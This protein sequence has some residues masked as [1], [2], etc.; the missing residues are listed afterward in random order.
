MGDTNDGSSRAAPSAQASVTSDTAV[1]HGGFFS[2]IIDVLSPSDTG[3]D[4][5][6]AVDTSSTST[7]GGLGNLRAMRLED[8]AIPKV[9][10]I[11]VPADI[12][13]D[14][15]VQL[16]RQSGLTRIPVYEGTLDTPIGLIHLKDFALKHGFEGNGTSFDVTEVM[17]PLLFAPPSMPIGVLLQKMQTAR[18]H[19]AL[20]IDE[21]GG[22]DGL[23][24]LED[25]VEQV[26]G[27]IE[28][29]HDL[30][31]DQFWTLEKPGCYLAVA[32]TPLDEFEAEIDASLTGHDEIDEEDIET[33]GGLVFML[34]GRVPERGEVVAH[35]AGFEFEV[36]DAD[37]RRIKRLR[38]R[39]PDGPHGAD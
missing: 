26:I 17:R 30:D 23:V 37:P 36:V 29:E 18:I 4:I 32:R 8:V 27:E 13:K 12:S 2:R 1:A 11:A 7:P 22:T 10:I 9:E 39:L 15:L 6:P 34:S 3:A 38:V 19:M 33:L 35:P 16:F 31:E 20:I 5:G 28:D 14:D 21:Y 24:T 25:L